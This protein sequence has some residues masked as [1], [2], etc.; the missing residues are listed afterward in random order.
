MITPVAQSRTAQSPRQG[1]NSKGTLFILTLLAVSLSL[2]AILGW[3]VRSSS[4]RQPGYDQRLVNSPPL[5]EGTEI[6]PLIAK[7]LDGIV[8]T[9]SF[10]DSD[11]P[12]VLYAFSLSCVWSQRNVDRIRAVSEADRSRFRFIGLSLRDEENGRLVAEQEKLGFQILKDLSAENMKAL[13]LGSTPQTIVVSPQRRV[14][15]NW[16]GF[17]AGDIKKQVCAFFDVSLPE[18][19]GN[20]DENTPDGAPQSCIRCVLDGLFSSVGAVV[21]RG[22]RRFRCGSDGRWIEL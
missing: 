2:N 13:G 12:T 10:G 5:V 18:T 17:F 4:V 9:I 16:I 3:Q 21:T 22:N 20:K 7:N 11:K 19:F 15:K 14:L 6:V 1:R 8:Q